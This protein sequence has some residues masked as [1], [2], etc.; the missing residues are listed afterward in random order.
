MYTRSGR[1]VKPVQKFVVELSDDEE[2]A[3]REE[4]H[5]WE[6][7]DLDGDMSGEYVEGCVDGCTYDGAC[8]NGAD[9]DCLCH[10]C[11]C[12]EHCDLDECECECHDGEPPHGFVVSSDEE[13]DPAEESMEEVSYEFET[14]S[15]DEESIELESDSECDCTPATSARKC[16]LSRRAPECDCE[17]H[18]LGDEVVLMNGERV[19]FE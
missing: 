14:E 11:G 15:Y 19:R 8:V 7:G 16:K 17:C 6:V 1:A 10:T 3:I 2:D 4:E 5:K 18:E 13:E 9:C 12:G